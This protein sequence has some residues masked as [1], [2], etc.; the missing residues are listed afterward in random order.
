MTAI[1]FVILIISLYK[2]NDFFPFWCSVVLFLFAYMGLM[3]SLFPYIV[4]F[5]ITVWQAASPDSSLRFLLFGLIL[6]IPVLLIYTGY[7]YHI[8]KGKVKNVFE[9]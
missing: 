4:P 5:Q 1:T 2:Q 9:Y 7:S 6:M 3:I 8:F